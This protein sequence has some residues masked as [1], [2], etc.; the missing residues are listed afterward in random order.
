MKNQIFE[1]FPVIRIYTKEP[2]KPATNEPMISKENATV[3]DAA[4]K[5]LKGMS[6]KIKQTKIWGPSSKFSGQVIGLEH[7]L[8]DKDTVEFQTK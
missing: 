4:E 8:K 7:K 1:T 3:E 2:H 5:I 6:K